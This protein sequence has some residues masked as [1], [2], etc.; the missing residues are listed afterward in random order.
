MSASPASPEL[1]SSQSVAL[2][3]GCRIIEAT[4]FGTAAWTRAARISITTAEGK[5]QAYFLKAS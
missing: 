4:T 2:P 3:D 1:S 5:P